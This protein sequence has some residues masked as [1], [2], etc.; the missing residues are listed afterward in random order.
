MSL[1]G[2]PVGETRAVNQSLA[3]R[4]T[5]LVSVTVFQGT[6]LWGLLLARRHLPPGIPHPP[7]VGSVPTEHPG[8]ALGA[9]CRGS[10]G[11]RGARSSPVC[12]A[13]ARAG[14]SSL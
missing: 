14:M 4:S 1:P 12:S 7:H 6:A 9:S 10:C 3:T 2:S 13:A 11:A 5:S 8:A